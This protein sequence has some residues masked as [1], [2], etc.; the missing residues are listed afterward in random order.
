M[1]LFGSLTSSVTGLAAQ[2]EA[3]SVISDNLSNA[4]T[5][6]YKSSRALF[7]QL[8]TSAGVSG[9]RYNAG[10]AHATVQRAQNQQGSL[11]STGSATD[12]ALSGSG[13][14]VVVSDRTIT[15]DTS[16]FF[17]RAGSFVEDSRGFL[18]HPSGNYLLGWRTNTAGDIIDR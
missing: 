16:V 13:F 9:V 2:S 3:I 12:L 18:Q 10:G 5:V 17:S 4:N 8:V 15:P 6:G 7:S 14:F 1:S 11:I